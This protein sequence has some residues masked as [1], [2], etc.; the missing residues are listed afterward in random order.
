MKERKKWEIMPRMMT[1]FRK[2]ME[3]YVYGKTNN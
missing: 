3:Q 2:I 1:I